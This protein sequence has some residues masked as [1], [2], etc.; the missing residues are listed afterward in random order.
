VR[1]SSEAEAPVGAFI[2][3]RDRRRRRN[4]TTMAQGRIR[5]HRSLKPLGVGV[6]RGFI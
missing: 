2:M 3:D 4:G 6:E 5:L 1:L